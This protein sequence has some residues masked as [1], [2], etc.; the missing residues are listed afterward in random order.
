MTEP[1]QTSTHAS[2]APPPGALLSDDQIKRLKV[3]VIVMTVLLIAGIALLIGRVIYLASGGRDASAQAATG[4][5]LVAETTLL[6]PEGAS[7]KS[8]TLTGN[9]VLAH[10]SGPRGEGLLVL[11]LTTGRTLSHVRISK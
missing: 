4:A 10:Y 5:P 7:L 9:R 11:D 6:L 1:S 2:A 8:S 3:V